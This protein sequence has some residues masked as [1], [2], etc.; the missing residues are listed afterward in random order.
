MASGMYVG[1]DD[2]DCAIHVLLCFCLLL[3]PVMVLF[4]LGLLGQ[5]KRKARARETTLKTY[6]LLLLYSTCVV[7]LL[8]SLIT[9]IFHISGFMAR[10]H[11]S[12][13]KW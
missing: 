9:Y 1:W 8:M 2:D 3:K 11:N 13:G 7:F 10:P 6:F 12:S 4:S 5:I